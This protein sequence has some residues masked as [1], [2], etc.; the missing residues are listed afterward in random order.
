LYS[1]YSIP[2]HTVATLY[3]VDLA[4]L[5]VPQYFLATST[6]PHTPYDDRKLAAYTSLM[7]ATFLSLPIYYLATTY[8][9]LTLVT[10]FD[11]VTLLRALPL[12]SIIALNLPAGYSLQTLLARYGV[13]GVLT[14]LADVLVTGSGLMY[15]GVSGAEAKGVQIVDTM[16]ILSIAVSVAATYGFVFRK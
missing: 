1:S 12:P 14:A 9:P 3:A 11:S 15:Y 4:S 13:K 2:W 5:V 7:S 10:Y 6:P 16:W 8:L